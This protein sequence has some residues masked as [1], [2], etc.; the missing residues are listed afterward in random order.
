MEPREV[1]L[2][3]ALVK[4]MDKELDRYLADSSSSSETMPQILETRQQMRTKELSDAVTYW[5]ASRGCYSEEIA[6][7]EDSRGRNTT[8]RR[9]RRFA[10][11]TKDKPCHVSW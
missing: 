6:N 8:I 4:D 11:K 9:K 7:Q 1:E 5:L 2:L 3:L 10:S